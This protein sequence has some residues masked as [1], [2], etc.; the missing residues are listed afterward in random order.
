MEAFTIEER[1][2]VDVQIRL[3]GGVAAA[4]DD[5][6]PVDVGPAKCQAVLAVLALSPGSAVPVSRIVRL[7]WGE[8][9]PRTADKTLQSYVT[10]LRKGLG[11]DSIVRTGVAYRLDVTAA[12]VDVV[13]FQRLLGVDDTEAALAEWTGTPLAG[14]DADGLTA[15]V[16][17]LIEQYLGVMETDLGQRIETDAHAV[18]GS[19]TEL[20]AT[21]PFREG[22]WALLMTA[23][24]RVGRQADALAA[25]RKARERL[26]EGLG[27][28]PGPRLRELESLIL[29]QDEQLGVNRSS[30]GSA[31]GAPSGT[32]T[33]G[34]SDVEDSTGLWAAHRREMAEAMARHDDLVA[35]AVDRH[36]GYIFATGGDSFGVAFHRASD[37]VAWATELQA[38]VTNEWPRGE[39][40][41]S[42]LDR[43]I[44]HAGEER[45]CG[46]RIN[47]VDI[48]VRI[49]LHTGETEE[50]GKGYFGPAVIIAARLAA[51]GHGGQ[52]LMSGVTSAL[53]DGSNL[54]DLGTYRLDGVVAEQRILQLGDGEHP[55]LRIDDSHRGN[56]PR[57]LGRLIGREVELEIIHDKLADF[58]IVTLVGPGGIGKTRLAMA[59]AERADVAVRAGGGGG[60]GS[61]GG[62]WLVELAGNASSSEVPR[63]VASVLDVKESLGRTLTESIV[64]ALRSRRALLVLDNCEHVIDGAADLARAVA[65]GCPNVRILATS[66]EGLGLRDEQLIVVAPLEPAGPGVELFNER[67]STASRMFDPTA[68]RDD[69][70]EICRRLDGVPLAIELA[71]ARAATLSPAELV[72][73]LDDRLRLLTG[74]RRASVERH[75]TLR[76]TIQ[77]SYD[78]LTAPQQALF[79]C[80]SIFA[81]TFDRLAAA[82]IVADSD[83]DLVDVDDLLGDLVDRSM[84]VVESGPFGRR[85][86]LLETIREFGAERLSQA[87]TTDVIAGRHA[88]WCLDEVTDIRE[89]LAG[90]AEIE[91]VARLD[92]LWPNLRAAFDWA[93]ATEHRR[94]ACALVAPVAAEVYLR[95][96]SEIGDWAER[97]LAITPPD[98]E[99]VIV[100]AL[101][102]A[103]RRYMRMLDMEGYERL[104]GR[105]GEPDHPMIRYARAFLSDDYA[106]RAESAAQSVTELRRRGEHYIADLNELVAVGL[107]MLMS[108]Q[109]D[110]HDALVTALAERYR[111]QGPPTC[112]QW[113]LT[114]LGISASVQGR[115]HDAA[116]FYEEAADVDVPDRTHTL[117]NPLEAREVLRRGDRR[118][119]F[120]ILR[121]YVDE[122][123]VNDNV[124]IGKFACIEFVGMMVKV[125][126]RPEAA[127]ILGFLESSG[128]LDISVLRSRFAGDAGTAAA[129]SEPDT[130]RER[131]LGRDLDDRGALSYIRDVLERLSTATS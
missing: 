29:G 75:R 54:R 80:L 56:L 78:L 106:R 121:A 129:D 130:D 102:W 83:L 27:V 113:A 97:I 103:A 55:P 109:L 58:A 82:A 108:G 32:V 53:L 50:R 22:L 104:V 16:D 18:I 51:A 10:R 9:P 67:A 89:L 117:K 5:G 43:P 14:L 28:E 79:Q 13:R 26:I 46:G 126:R 34:F 118:R 124:F 98:D 119:A 73:R 17:G 105:Y 95:S 3:F 120:E 19:L 45:A 8:D 20:T 112:L 61:G 69:V 38:A 111:A 74:G 60:A 94:L 24:Y 93:C 107:T 131:A 123:L 70:E 2:A 96:R 31:L 85:F 30:M 65:E 39:S 81:G 110:E 91:G 72:A 42:E 6:E 4:T 66:R 49:G 77:W 7:V 87:G 128:A 68:S 21:Y 100:F 11:P 12:S 23:L 71:A 57:R 101:T 59:A 90:R 115:H 92:E 36:G 63:A 15:T 41:R 84:L 1:S 125:D 62:A 35:A 64:M 114:Y 86:R 48:R 52:T 99:E 37:S 122:L 40:S 44:R 33:F 116:K 88:Q 47:S 76:A 127:R 25:Y